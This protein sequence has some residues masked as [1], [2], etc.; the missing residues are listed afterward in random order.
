MKSQLTFLT[1]KDA[2]SANAALALQIGSIC[3][4]ADQ[5]A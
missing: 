2:A 5:T 3:R 4:V 1:F